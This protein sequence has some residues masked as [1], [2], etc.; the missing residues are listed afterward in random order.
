MY[1]QYLNEDRAAQYRQHCEQEAATERSLRASREG[2]QEGVESS[3]IADE[4]LLG[5]WLRHL[6]RQ[7]ASGLLRK[8]IFKA[9]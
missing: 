8:R 9:R 7:V 3:E 4:P 2:E 1:Q 5:S 6:G